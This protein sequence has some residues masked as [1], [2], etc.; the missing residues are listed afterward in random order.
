VTDKTITRS[1][2]SHHRHSSTHLF[3]VV[4]SR[5][6]RLDTGCDQ[7]DS[8]VLAALRD[9]YANHTELIAEAFTEAHK[10][11]ASHHA[12]R[13]SELDAVTA[14]ITKTGNA[15]D[16][17][18]TAF[19][20]ETM[21]EETAAPRLEK[22]ATKLRQLKQRRDELAEEIDT[23]PTMPTETELADILTHIDQVIDRQQPAA[24]KALIDALV[25]RVKVV[26]ATQLV[27][28]FRVHHGHTT[29]EDSD[30]DPAPAATQ[31][32]RADQHEHPVRT[33]GGVVGR[34][35]LE[36]RTYGLK[37]RSSTN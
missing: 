26:S 34:L 29:T 16:R 12:D 27:P 3:A 24:T 15:I 25:A 9:F 37:V 11:H 10:F 20:N 4:N 33:M 2:P 8:A 5:R 23:A 7:V 22:L 14:E 30:D 18:F 17:Y 6:E 28:V 35:G 21:S 32:R 19:E 31:P 36:P 13:I 1:Q